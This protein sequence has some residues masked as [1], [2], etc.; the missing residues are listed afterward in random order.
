VLVF[1]VE[2]Y[3]EVDGTMYPVKNGA[4]TALAIWKSTTQQAK[5]NNQ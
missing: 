3:Q 5:V 4:F 1:G 2:S